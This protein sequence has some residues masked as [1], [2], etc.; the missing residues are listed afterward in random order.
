MSATVSGALKAYIES[1]GLGLQVFRDGA[2]TDQATGL[3]ELSAYPF[4]VVQEGIAYDQRSDGDLGDS[5]AVRTVRELVQVD[6]YQLA[7]AVSGGTSVS[8]ESYALADTLRA[9]LHGARLGLVGTQQVDGVLTRGGQRWPI[10]DNVVRHTITLE[11]NR[12]LNR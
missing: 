2:P 11:I 6:V 10:S 8:T 1:L 3:P 7:R 4:A 5:A 9:R 12:T